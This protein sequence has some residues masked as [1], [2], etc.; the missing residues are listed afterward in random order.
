V[1]ATCGT[2]ERC[3]EDTEHTADMKGVHRTMGE[4]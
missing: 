3:A 2:Y 1:I 4:P